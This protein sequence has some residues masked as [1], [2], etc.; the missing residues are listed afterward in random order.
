VTASLNPASPQATRIDIRSILQLTEFADLV[1]PFTIRAVAE[2]GIADR[3][4]DGPLSVEQ[5]AE[6][7]GADPD[8]LYRALRVLTGR[9]IFAETAPGHFALTP[10]S[11]LLRDD[12]PYSLRGAF[13]LMRGDIAA[14]GH[15]DYSVRTGR[16][17]FEHAHGETYWDYMARRPDESRRLN[18]A[19]QAQTRLELRVVLR[20]FEWSSFASVADIGGGNGSFLAGLL[21]QNPAMHGVL[22]DLA[23]VVVDAP[24]TL[25]DAGVQDRCEIV[26][27]N[28]FEQIPADLD[29]YVL[30]RVLYGWSD[31][32]AIRLLLQIRRALR[33]DGRLLILEPVVGVSR[34]T[35]MSNRYD[36]RM[37]AMVGTRVRTPQEIDRLLGEAGLVR[38]R[39]I[40]TLMFPIMEARA[41]A[42]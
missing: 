41:A 34:D 12:H 5:L 37:L 13:P 33:P 32:D 19:Q 8:S 20:A 4:A 29:V 2:L 16:S 23:H 22:L 10:L 18:Q 11:Q 35:D 9:G 3:L 7:V 26:A 17:A 28:F 30:K 36:L 25:R 24:A 1:I 40:T 38:T 42:A 31:D 6:G 39:M 27:G 21:A 14:W 15:F